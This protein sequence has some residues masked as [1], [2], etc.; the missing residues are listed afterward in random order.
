MKVEHIEFLVE[1]QS[2]ETFLR[3]LVPRL[4]VDATFDV[5]A[6]QGKGDLLKKLPQ[7]LLA[8]GK[9]IPDSWRI[10]VIVDRDEDDCMKLK[11]RLE[12]VAGDAGFGTRASARRRGCRVV[13]RLAIRELE[14]W[15]FGDWEAV[16]AAYPRVSRN[17]PKREAY[18]DPD[19]IPGT[20][21]AFERLLQGKGYFRGGLRKVEAARSVAG[22]MDPGRN[23][24][25]SF[26]VFRDVLLEMTA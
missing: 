4:I 1:E 25:R 21:E 13:N 16:R 7:R 22:H 15:Y 11:S 5:H 14:A 8:Y 24:S 19:D 26:Q 9:W 2:M 18:R 6:Y 20:W 3:V 12:T 17:T 10:V 23:S